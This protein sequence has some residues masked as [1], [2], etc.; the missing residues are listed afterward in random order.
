M[1]LLVTKRIGMC[2]HAEHMRKQHE[3]KCWLFPLKRMHNL[4]VNYLELSDVDTGFQKFCLLPSWQQS[5]RLGSYF[6]YCSNLALHMPAN[7]SRRNWARFCNAL[8]E[9]RIIRRESNKRDAKLK[10]VLKIAVAVGLKTEEKK[11]NQTKTTFLNLH[12]TKL[13]SVTR[14]LF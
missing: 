12:K 7:P 8:R 6:F 4:C 2:V 9:K 3:G 10:W 1:W 13:H 5:V 11:A 14:H